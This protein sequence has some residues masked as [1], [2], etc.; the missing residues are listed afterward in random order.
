LRFLA[1][2]SLHL[3]NGAKYIIIRKLIR[4]TIESSFHDFCAS[5]LSHAIS[6]TFAR[7]VKPATME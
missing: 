7:D 1:N 6:V 3:N 2:K 5:T 4:Q